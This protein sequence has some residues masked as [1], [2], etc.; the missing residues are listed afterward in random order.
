VLLADKPVPQKQI[1]G[2]TPKEFVESI[3]PSQ[4]F[5]RLKS[6]YRSFRKTRT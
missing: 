6:S 3:E 4:M 2:G 5:S 1:F